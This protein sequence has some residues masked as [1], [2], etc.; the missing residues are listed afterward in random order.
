[1]GG[2]KF[3]EYNKLSRDIWEWAETRKIHLHASYI[4][5]ADNKVADELSRLKN[6][7]TEWELNSDVFR[8]I[9]NNFGVPQI[10]LFATKSNAKCDQFVSWKPDPQAKV[11]DAFTISWKKLNFYA[12][13]PFSQ[14]LKMLMKI[15]REKAAGIIIVPNW[16]GQ[17]W[18][19]LFKEL[20][21]GK[22][23]YFGPCDNLL[24]SPYRKQTHPQKKHLV[25]IAARVSG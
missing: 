8:I 14:I 5:S 23:L 24:L 1:M 2:V 15:K 21:V 3:P 19:P 7:D 11:V 10:D 12:F 9:S 13:P 6:D 16:T 20:T 4:K 17:A 22:P 18:F 25:F